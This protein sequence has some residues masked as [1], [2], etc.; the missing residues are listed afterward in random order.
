MAK[1]S[2]VESNESTEINS[3][4]EA[5][6][7][8]FKTVVLNAIYE[9]ATDIHLNKVEDGTLILYRVD[10]IIYEKQLVS[11]TEG[12]QLIN[13]IKVAAHLNATKSFVPQ[14]GQVKWPDNETSR[15]I[16]VTIVPAGKIAESAH[17][18]I[19]S[20]PKEAWKISNLGFAEDDIR[21]ITETIHS[22]GG[23]VLISGHTGSG[24]TTT[25]YSLASLMNLRNNVAFSIEDPIE[26]NLPYAQQLEVDERHGLTMYQGLQTILRTDPDLVMVGEIRDRESAIVVSRAALSGRL[27]LGTIHAKDAAGTIDALHYLGVPYYI[28]GGSIKLIVSQNLLRK[29]CPSCAKER[30]LVKE[31]KELFKEYGLKVPRKIFNAVGCNECGF[32]GYKGRIGIFE[33]AR[34]DPDTAHMIADGIHQRQLRDHLRKIQISPM[35]VDGL[36]KVAQGI[37]SMDELYRVSDFKIEE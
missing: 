20:F 26:F 19:L 11:E 13:Q 8:P 16:R 1:S 25:M 31:E 4:V 21:N 12:R 15:D 29:L 36:N 2:Q 6:P 14:E 17:L 37:T 7:D 32:Y 5:Y 10:G 9:N 28:I 27:V 35:L 3:I 24:K 18:R 22:M 23:M 33:V 30:S 34:I